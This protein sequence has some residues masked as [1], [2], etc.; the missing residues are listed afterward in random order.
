MKQIIV[1]GAC[2][3]MG[4]MICEAVNRNPDMC[5]VGAVEGK[6]H[7]NVGGMVAGRNALGGTVTIMQ[8]WDNPHQLADAHIVIDF[9]TPDSTISTAKKIR[10]LNVKGNPIPPIMLV[11]GTTGF[12]AEQQKT[13]KEL[14]AGVT[15]CVKSDNMS[16]GVNVMAITVELLAKAL[17]DWDTEIVE[18]HHK[19]KK[20][21]PSGTAKKILAQAIAEAR[22]LDL[23]KNLV[24]TRAG[25]I[26]AR[27]PDEIGV[28]SLRGGDVPGEHTA[29]FFGDQERIEIIHRASSPAIFVN[30]ALAATRWLIGKPPE[31]TTGFYTMKDVLGL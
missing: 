31:S 19:N 25:I 3:R 18:I 1:I 20:D 15:P 14:V 21:A 4:K 24:C 11:V 29:Y 9:S 23:E 2:G 28:Q 27:K 13:F 7:P 6:M 30:G 8:E 17:R 12:T 10:A 26:G 16:L 22:G 5:L